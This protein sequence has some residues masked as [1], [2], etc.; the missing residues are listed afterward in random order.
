[1][2][3]T[4]RLLLFVVVVFVFSCVC[5]Q[6]GWSSV[7]RRYE[8]WLG[9][10]VR[11][12]FVGGLE[13]QLVCWLVGGEPFSHPVHGHIMSSDLLYKNS[14][15]VESFGWTTTGRVNLNIRLHFRGVTQAWGV[16]YFIPLR[17]ASWS[18]VHTNTIVPRTDILYDDVV[19]RNETAT[20]LVG[21]LVRIA[22]IPS[23]LMWLCWWRPDADDV[24]R[25]VDVVKDVIFWCW[26]SLGKDVE[27]V[28]KQI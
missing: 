14:F 25:W 9:W 3:S 24:I 16:L 8:G 13:G 4:E 28:L 1:M 11:R 12:H 27:V 15:K 23:S 18:D 17:F 26:L 19:W 6:S 7:D 22:W 20:D 10:L 21:R 5:D 2:F